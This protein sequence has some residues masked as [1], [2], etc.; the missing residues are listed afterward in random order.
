M[1]WRDGERAGLYRICGW[2]YCVLVTAGGLRAGKV[3][4]EHTVA[5]I[6]G[7]YRKCVDIFEKSGSVT[8]AA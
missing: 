1:A 6:S 3:M 5:A 7:R 2:A 8:A 4:R